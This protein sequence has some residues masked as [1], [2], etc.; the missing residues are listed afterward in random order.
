MFQ[1]ES[2]RTSGMY[3]AS[4]LGVWSLAHAHTCSRCV[5]CTMHRQ[6]EPTQHKERRNTYL[7][8]LCW[9]SQ[10][11]GMVVAGQGALGMS[12]SDMP[13]CC[14]VTKGPR[15]RPTQAFL[16][17]LRTDHRACYAVR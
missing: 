10:A 8:C 12:A 5:P 9:C 17:S 6:D 14:S 2:S 11:A 13:W 3:A 16:L 7:K 4:E 1:C 15:N